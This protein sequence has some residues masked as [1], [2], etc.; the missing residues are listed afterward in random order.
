MPEGHVTVAT[1]RVRD[2][3]FTCVTLYDVPRDRLDYILAA[4]EERGP[5]ADGAVLAALR[6][7]IE[8]E[9]ER[10]EGLS[11]GE[12]DE[13]LAQDRSIGPALWLLKNH[14]HGAVKWPLDRGWIVG[15]CEDEERVVIQQIGEAF[16]AHLRR[17]GATLH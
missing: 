6:A 5:W 10:G 14:G 4:F 12:M 7:G 8:R 3:R 2:D 11:E 17:Q 16:L 15:A 9:V 13:L 1:V